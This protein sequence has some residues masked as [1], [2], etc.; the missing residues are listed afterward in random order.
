MTLRAGTRLGAYEVLGVIGAGGMGEV[1]RAID[2]RLDRHVAIKVLPAGSIGDRDAEAR[3]EREAR[4]TAA[5]SHPNICALFDVGQ[6]SFS[7]EDGGPAST[8]SYLV[9]ELLEGETLHARLAR[10]PFDIG[11]FVEYAISLADA[12]DSAHARGILHRDL[13]PGNVFLTNRGHLKILDFGLAK[14]LEGSE[15]TTREARG[16]ITGNGAL[17]GTAAYMSPEQLRG[18]PADA[19]SDLFA[20]G[21]VLY[22]MTTGRRAFPG[23]TTAVVTAKILSA[24]PDDPRK[25]RPDLP[26][27]VSD[28]ILK[29]LEK[30]R[31]LRCQS[32][33]ELRADLKRIRRLD[34][35]AAPAQHE[36][37]PTPPPLPAQ[38]EATGRPP[39]SSDV[40]LAVGLIRRHPIGAV[41]ALLLTAGA[42]AAAVVMN[43][44][45]ASVPPAIRD[46][47]YR[48][49]ALTLSGDA[50]LGA[51]SADGKFLAY[52]RT[53]GGTS[54]VW[55]RQIPGAGETRRVAEVPGRRFVGLT[56]TPDGS[57]DFVARDGPRAPA[58]WRVSLVGSSEPRAVAPDV[59]SATAWSPDARRQAFI[60][61]N[62]GQKTSA[63]VLAD[64]DGSNQRVLAT[65]NG[66]ETFLSAAYVP[67][68]TARPSWSADG[69]RLM[70]TARTGN[71]ARVEARTPF[72]LIVIDVASGKE[73]RVVPLGTGLVG[74]MWLDD[75]RAIISNGTPT[76]LS[77]VRLATGQLS[78][79]TQDLSAYPDVAPAA[80]GAVSTRRDVRSSI[81]IGNAD[82]T[83]M[84]EAVAESPA[85]P[86]GVSMD[87]SGQLVYSARTG[88]GR[89]ISITRPG[90]ASRLVAENGTVPVITGDGRTVC[91][92]GTTRRGDGIWCG[93]S[94]GSNLTRRFDGLVVHGPILVPGDRDV[95]FVTTRG[96]ERGLWRLPVAGGEPR[97]L[98]GQTVGAT[99]RPFVSPDGRR[100]RYRST[101][102][103]N[104]GI[105]F[106]CDLPDC[107]NPTKEIFTAGTSGRAWMPDGRTVAHVDE[108]D[109]MNVWIRPAAGAPARPVTRFTD[110]EVTDVAWSPDGK[111]LIVNRRSSVSDVVL[112]RGV[113]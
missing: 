100:V 69:A 39:S 64:P 53:V 45:H 2:T 78:P 112:I 57:I 38:K 107:A 94:D 1:Y 93:G 32:A 73:Q 26:E 90:Q 76:R 42:L 113:R 65:R 4:A 103:Q 29:T 82:G 102:E 23:T 101:D 80:G 110:R 8:V 46:P 13:K 106:E 87:L 86:A 49:E 74:A 66:L 97:L 31:D 60:R 104:R 22:E 111:R 79:I 105:T 55:V 7:P 34:S 44:P 48:V 52:V 27:R 11:T 95:L 28:A 108:R 47:G 51:L 83:A 96:D 98:S 30:N 10:G 5:L 67:T 17:V 68:P 43:R 63:V 9:M 41:A 59:W 92:R 25:V 75:D 58:L 91:F 77:V 84:T 89:D 33:A 3:F 109:P 6:A 24:D 19:R 40:Q 37:A 54:T 36:D 62:F 56:I 15:M 12:L 88:Q 21:L 14:A 35:R 71:P 16:P 85:E 61:A 81:W 72:E 99:I 50:S 18:E 20:L 70:V